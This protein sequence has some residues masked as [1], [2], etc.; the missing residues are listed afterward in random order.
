MATIETSYRDPA[1]SVEARVADLLAR[2]TLPEKVGQMLQLN[3]R[4]GVRHLVE[5]MHAGSILHASPERVLEATAL[6]ERTRLRIPLL[7]AEDCIHGHSFWSGATIFPTQLGMAASWD[8]ELVERVARVTAVEVAA[9]G[10]HWTFSPVLCIARDLRWGRVSETFGED[11]FLIGEHGL[12]VLPITSLRLNHHAPLHR[13]P[14]GI[15][16]LD[17]MLGGKGVFRGASVLISGSPGT[18]KSSVSASFVDAACRRGERALLFAYEESSAQIVRNMRSIGIDLEHWLK[19][20]L[21]QI[22]ASRPTLHGLEQHL[23]AMHDTVLAFR[24]SMVAVDPISN[25]TMEL[26]DVELKP[27]L[28]R[29]IDSL[30]QEQITAVFTSLT[31]G[32]SASISPEDSQVGVSSL[33]D[34]WLLLRNHEYNGERNRTIF[35]L[36]A[37]GMAHSNQIREFILGSHGIELVDVYLGNEGVLTGTARVTQEAN[38]RAAA[39]R[40]RQDHQRKLRQLASKRK[41][42]EAQIAVLKGEAEAEA[43]ELNLALTERSLQETTARNAA[44]A[45]SQLR[46]GVKTDNHRTKQKR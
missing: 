39:E 32:G 45:L 11:P 17:E 23:V 33:M 22:H 43:E 31:S 26:D 10:I 12:S 35:V 7:V 9:T 36:K 40:R 4:D 18:G 3:A 46:G 2:M 41:A 1:L 42:I 15:A 13:V 8:P 16:G 28:M 14:T 30:K 25:L 19:K 24:P 29:L 37:R 6:V 21:L 38:E 20:G 5:D 27:T 34:V 44:T